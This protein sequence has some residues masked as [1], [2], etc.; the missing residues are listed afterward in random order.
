[1]SVQNLK[2]FRQGVPEISVLQDGQTYQKT[3]VTAIAGV[4]ASR[5]SAQNSTTAATF[6]F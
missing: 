4:E 1:M 5:I 3:C 2:T 6:L